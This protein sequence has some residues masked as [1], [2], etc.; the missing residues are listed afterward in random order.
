MLRSSAKRFGTKRDG[1]GGG[2]Y[3]PV[4][5]IVEN[6]RQSPRELSGIGARVRGMIC[7][8]VYLLEAAT[9]VLAKTPQ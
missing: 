1:E 5:I 3:G 7:L 8:G 6:Q 2:W 4:W 9:T